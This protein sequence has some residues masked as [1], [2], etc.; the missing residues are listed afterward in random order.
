MAASKKDWFYVGMQFLLFAA[1][2]FEIPGLTLDVPSSADPVNM[3]LAIVGFLIIFTAMVQLKKNL[4]P[5]PT[6]KKDADLVTSGL[7]EYVRHPIYTGILMVAFFLAL[8]FHSGY[9]MF[10]F[11]LL[12]LLFY[13]KSEYEEEKLKNRH[14]GYDKYRAETGRFFPKI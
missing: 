1:Y 10:I 8:Y 11:L 9:K 6:P 13:Y 12:V 2:V 3:V 14:P 5:F 7:F 4:S